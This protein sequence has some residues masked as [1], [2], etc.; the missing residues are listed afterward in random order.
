MSFAKAKKE[1]KNIIAKKLKQTLLKLN[2][3]PIM[4]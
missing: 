1:D 3:D 2:K 4:A